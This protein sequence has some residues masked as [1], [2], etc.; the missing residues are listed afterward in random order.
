MVKEKSLRLEIGKWGESAALNY[1]EGEG[2]TLVQRNFRSPDGEIDL[3]M[4]KN[5]ELVFVEVKTRTSVDFG[6][7]EEAVDDQNLITFEATAGWFLV[8][9]AEFEENWRLDIVAVTGKL[10]SSSPEINGL[11]MLETPD[12][13]GPRHCR[14]TGIGNQTWQLNWQGRSMEKSSPRIRVICTGD[15]YRHCQNLHS[16]SW[17]L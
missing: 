4:R 9:H 14:L 13:N 17:V 8:E 5:D 15:E 12:T 3:I 1:L 11:S 7:P 16:T 2:Y 10:G 6:F